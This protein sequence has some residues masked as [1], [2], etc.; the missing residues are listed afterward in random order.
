MSAFEMSGGVFMRGG[1]F[2]RDIELKSLTSIA[3]SATKG[4]ITNLLILG[5]RG[6]GKTELL[7][8]FYNHLFEMQ[9]GLIP[10][11][12]TPASSL[13]N[14]SEDYLNSF[15]QQSIAFLKKDASLLNTTITP[16]DAIGTAGDDSLCI[17]TELL[18]GYHE[19]TKK[20]EPLKSLQY[21]ISIPYRCISFLKKPVIIL[22]D[23]FD[24]L[25]PLLSSCGMFFDDHLRSGYTPHVITGSRGS[26]CDIFFNRT[27]LGKHLEI[28]NLGGLDKESSSS[29]FKSLCRAYNLDVRYPEEIIDHLQGNPLYIK[30]FVSAIRS[31]DKQADPER[32]YLM[33]IT[34]GG[35]FM[36]WLS[37]LK[38][39][40]PDVMR[41]DA[42]RLLYHLSS[43]GIHG[44]STTEDMTSVVKQETLNELIPL[45]RSADII[46]DGFTSLR[47][48]GD[49]VFVDFIKNLYRTELKGNVM[50]GHINDKGN[51]WEFSFP[52]GEYSAHVAMRIFEEVARSHG[53]S[54]DMIGRSQIAIAE[55][56]NSLHIQGGCN[57]GF[58]MG[59][60]GFSVKFDIPSEG[61]EI[62][63]EA[64]LDLIK[65]I[66]DDVRIERSEGLTR[67]VMSKGICKPSLPSLQ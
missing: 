33:D 47:L 5:G 3:L 46:E 39:Y 12:Y 32:A 24:R 6:V 64:S 31:S 29:L 62:G 51:S 50:K 23:D 44:K 49:R 52:P 45:L 14:L 9:D 11:L 61:V 13:D 63:D 10:F 19:V 17:L 27:S 53:V 21:A 59:D 43:Q 34:N 25:A 42:L 28:M 16:E 41:M 57:L 40:I 35:I 60:D 7:R 1:F 8:R 55:I 56:I 20:G 58:K 15:I 22:I 54:P 67:L 4:Y 26:L 30:R 48:V 38:R 2:G 66:F 18:R 36:Y 37:H 65:G